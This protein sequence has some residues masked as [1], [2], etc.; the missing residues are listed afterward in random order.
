MLRRDYPYAHHIY[1]RAYTYNRSHNYVDS[2][3][4]NFANVLTH[5]HSCPFAHGNS[6]K[7]SNPNAETHTIAKP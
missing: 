4:H 3:V 6:H 1:G 5:T 7:D 2:Y